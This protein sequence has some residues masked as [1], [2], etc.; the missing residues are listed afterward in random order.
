MYLSCI[1]TFAWYG[2]IMKFN[3]EVIG[4]NIMLNSDRPI[5]WAKEDALNRSVFA[6]NLAKVTLDYSVPEGFAIGLYGKWGSGKTSV[7]NMVLEQIEKLSSAAPQKPVVLRFNPWL[8]SDPKQLISQFLKQLSSAIKAKQPKLDSVCNFINDYADAFDIVGAIPIVGKFLSVAGKIV[9]KKAKAYSDS[10][11]RD[12]QRIKD[13]I[14][15]ILLKERIKIIITID[16]IDR[17]SNDEIISVFQLVKSLADFPYTIYFLAFD[18]EVVIRALGEVQKGN[19]EEY[20]QKII[21]VPFELPAP[22]AEDIFEIF[23][24]KLNPI[25][26]ISEEHLHKAYLGEM[27]HYGIKPYMKTIRDV[28]RF[29]NTFTLKYTLLKNETS[30]IDLLGLTCLQVFEAEVY[31][32]LPH[33]KNHLCGGTE[34]VF[35]PD[36][37][38]KQTEEIQIAY[39]AIIAGAS[40]LHLESIERLLTMLFSK[41]SAIADNTTALIFSRQYSRYDTLS[42]GNISNPDCFDRYF[43]LTLEPTAISKIDIDYLLF[44]ATEEELI[45]GIIKMSSLKKASRLLDH[46]QGAYT[47]KKNNRQQN[48]ERAKL[49]FKCLLW[50]WHNLD[51]DK[52]NEFSFTSLDRLLIYTAKAL[53]EEINESERYD[54]IRSLFSDAKVDISTSCS[55]LNLFEKQHDRF[56]KGKTTRDRQLLPLENILELEELLKTKIV[57]QIETGTLL[58]NNSAQLV[59]WIFEQIDPEGAKACVKKTID[60]DLSLAK[61][62][63]ALVGHGKGSDG[64]VVYKF[65]RVQKEFIKD[66]MDIDDASKRMA[67]FVHSKGFLNL[68]DNKQEN[69]AAFLIEMTEAERMDDTILIDD[70]KEKLRS[71]KEKIHERSN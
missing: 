40:E 41:L 69:I 12:L 9:G 1:C 55:L 56:V 22:L 18:R 45:K 37:S 10:R 30:V 34:M 52:E 68:P 19:G 38:R 6:D 3:E 61:L 36:Q 27:L 11:S 13:E 59:L 4:V 63:S 71:I 32:K 33:H 17:L 8:C 29:T 64:R 25:I 15:S 5:N 24:A 23:C 21:Q 51:D 58:D 70:I 48:T 16:D 42:N 28:V 44:Q 60:S 43:T 14:T 66:Y 47:D 31:S 7:I 26:D 35:S 39:D 46:I 2:D 54:L 50:N 20:L 57:H 53:L 49:I 62:V 65:W 67:T